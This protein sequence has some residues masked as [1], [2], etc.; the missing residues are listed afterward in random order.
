M[1]KLAGNTIMITAES[2]EAT[3][4]DPELIQTSI[5]GSFKA[6][7]IHDQWL[8][9]DIAMAVEF[10][11]AQ[12]VSANKTFSASE[13]NSTIVKILEDNGFPEAS[14]HYRNYNSF[15]KIT[16]NADPDTVKVLLERQL[17]LHGTILQETVDK[18]VAAAQRLGIEYAAP[19][20][21]LE[22]ARH[23]KTV[24]APL[25]TLASLP[26][27]A[28]SPV[29]PK[30]R[31]L[32]TTAE[33]NAALSPESR[34][35]IDAGIVLPKGISSISNSLI[36]ELRLSKL[37]AHLEFE[38]VITEMMLMP[39]FNIAATALNECFLRTRELMAEKWNPATIP[40]FLSV[41]DMSVFAVKYL[42]AEWPEAK[43]DCRYLLTCLSKSLNFDL[44]NTRM[45]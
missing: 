2:G 6:A 21:Y 29:T 15:A 9:E 31:Y 8:A 35:M 25:P 23:F 44:F 19:A 4:F 27:T 3:P 45:A 43:K 32:L 1:I 17:A 26:A 33:I 37:A 34:Q 12:N 18:V 5:V 16:I 24:T 7:G 30:P 28:H 42:E 11:L 38:P 40:V 14:E 22:M 20:L 13:I 39:H 10:A 41:P 36:L